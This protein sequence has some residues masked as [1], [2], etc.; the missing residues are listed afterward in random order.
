MIFS[1]RFKMN[2]AV[3][4]CVDVQFDTHHIKSCVEM[5]RIDIIQDKTMICFQWFYRFSSDDNIYLC[6]ALYKNLKISY[7]WNEIKKILISV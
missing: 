7:S 4:D 1:I 6:Q 3:K 5:F 2:I